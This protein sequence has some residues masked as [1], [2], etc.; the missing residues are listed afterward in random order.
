MKELKK[1]LQILLILILAL[2]IFINVYNFISIKVLK[3]RYTSIMGYTMLEVISGSMEPTIHINDFIIVNTNSKEF[4]END[5]ITYYDEENNF[6]THRIIKIEDDSFI[7]K[8][9]HNDSI[10]KPISKEQVLGKYVLKFTGAGKIL[11]AFKNPITMILIF[12]VGLLMCVFIS[13]DKNG[14]PI[15]DEDEKEFAEFL[16][17]K[18][19]KGKESNAPKKEKIKKV[20]N[21]K[22]IKKEISKKSSKPSQ[23]SST[24]KTEPKQISKTSSAKTVASKKNSANKQTKVEQNVKAGSKTTT[25]KNNVKK[26]TK[27]TTKK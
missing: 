5:I 20:E 23:N 15:I 14:N 13:T 11:G 24:R 1:G 12:I 25:S 4:S 26:N 7:T 27:N 9:D 2:I 3:N 8:G 21:K 22:E 19:K 10:D 18:D 16:K 6:V 17:D